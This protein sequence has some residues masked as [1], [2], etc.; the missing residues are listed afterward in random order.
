MMA[1]DNGKGDSREQSRKSD[2][3]STLSSEQPTSPQGRKW[4]QS[5][6]DLLLESED[7]EIATRFP[8]CYAHLTIGT[9]YGPKGNDIIID[10][11]N[12]ANRQ[13]I[14]K[15]I[16]DNLFFN[17][18]SSGY[19]I[20]LNGTPCSFSQLQPND[21]LQ[22]GN[23]TITVLNLPEAVA[24]LEGYSQPH[25][26]QQW[27]LTQ[28]RTTIGRAGRRENIVEL[29]DPTVSRTH[30]TIIQAE[31][32]FIIQPDGDRPIWVNG[33][34]V[35][36]MAIL[37]DEDLI[38]AGS[39]TLRF[40]S[41][42]AKGKPRALL[43]QEATILFS[44][45]WNYTSMAE[46]RPLEE[47]IGQ[48]NEVYKKL[49]RVIINN[50]G[51]LMT[52]LGDAMMAVFGSDENSEQLPGNHAEQAVC[53]ALEMLDAMKALNSD[54]KS[55][56]YPQLQL[57]VGVA[58]GEVMVGDVGVTGHREFAAMGDTT[59]VA[60]RIE[61]LTRDKGVHLLIN[62][63]TARQIQSTF[64]LQQLDTVEVKGRRKP[65]TL[66]QVTGRL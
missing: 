40:R 16:D 43:P 27:T 34:P 32:H 35:K 12:M 54:W 18:L 33:E 13:A 8:V 44:D 53:A 10:E 41:Y 31:G 38:Q 19:T 49:G 51:T 20:L 14:L 37:G 58:T 29:D 48:L 42:R 6:W 22:F 64:Q 39:Q 50:H 11:P 65:V 25:R 17:S 61:K 56:G 55:R 4:L 7:G 24:F 63:E 26:R 1:H 3:S 59:N 9:R 60:S 28:S 45:I 52:Y 30:A 36:T 5:S 66:Y 2:S 23:H 47:T 15:I 57:G 46:S 62:E 21:V